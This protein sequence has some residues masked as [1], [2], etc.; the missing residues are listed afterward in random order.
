MMTMRGWVLG[1]VTALALQASVANG[2]ILFETFTSFGGDGWLSPGEAPSALTTSGNTQRGMAY[3][4]MAN[5]LYVVN[6]DNGTNVRILDASSGAVLGNLAA[7]DGGFSG[8]TFTGNMV[9]VASDGAIYMAN[10]STSIGANFKVYRWANAAAAP[11]V[12]FEA[13]SGLIRTGDTFSVIGSGVDTR[14]VASGGSGSVGVALLSTTDG[15]TFTSTI[16]NPLPAP[17]GSFRIGLDFL[18]ADTIIGKQTVADFV[19]G[20]LSTL[21]TTSIPFTAGGE[22]PL[23]AFGDQNLLASVDVNSSLVRFYDLAAPGGPALSQSLS[24]IIGPSIANPNAVG[25]L[26]FGVDSDG[27]IRLYALN[28]N[29]GIQAFRSV[30]AIPEPSSLVAL[31]IVG[32]GFVVRRRRRRKLT[33]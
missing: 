28:T 15:T 31:G 3:S 5:H 21:T 33:D 27:F 14:I 32:I 23:A 7:P 29:N 12:A 16:A 4:P 10:L 22:G 2:A 20:D 26:D 11:T 9:S 18:D 8:G 6:R 13:P 25:A 1:L 19:V 17:V 24:A 30:V